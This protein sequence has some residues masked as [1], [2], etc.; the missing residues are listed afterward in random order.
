MSYQLIEDLQMKAVTVSQACRT[1]EVSRSGYYAAAKRLQYSP[2]G[3][4]CQRSSEGGFRSQW[5]YLR[6]SQ[7]ARCAGHEWRDDGASQGAQLDAGQR[8]A[9]G[10]ETQVYAHHRQQTHHASVT[11]YAGSPV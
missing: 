5:A 3:V 7:T 4:C 9:P 10:V 2:S 11:Q 8:A 6:Q 1:L